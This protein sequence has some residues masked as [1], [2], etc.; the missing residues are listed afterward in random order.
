MGVGKNSSGNMFPYL[1]KVFRHP[2]QIQKQPKFVSVTR[3][4]LCGLAS[5]RCA[6][7]AMLEEVWMQLVTDCGNC[8][9]ML[10]W[11]LLIWVVPI[12]WCR[13]DWVCQVT[14]LRYCDDR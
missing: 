3:R 8:Y 4:I 5:R 1:F 6:Y 12:E 11:Y 7:E 9:N 2:S 10:A 13:Q 14:G